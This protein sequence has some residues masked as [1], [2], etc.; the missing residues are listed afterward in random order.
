MSGIKLAIC[1][2]VVAY[3]RRGEDYD[4]EEIK[5]K[6]EMMGERKKDK[7]LSILAKNQTGS[8]DLRPSEDFQG[9]TS[10]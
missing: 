5:V 10:C 9:G 3:W 6:V 4:V 7:S 2:H 8:S 1:D